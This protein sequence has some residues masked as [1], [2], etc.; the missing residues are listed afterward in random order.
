VREVERE[1]GKEKERKKRDRVGDTWHKL[2][3][4]EEIMKSSTAN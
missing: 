2:S 3:G 1:R 4:C